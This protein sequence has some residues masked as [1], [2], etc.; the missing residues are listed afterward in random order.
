M[1]LEVVEVLT[2]PGKKLC[3]KHYA[4]QYE[5]IAKAKAQAMA[6]MEAHPWRGMDK[7][8]FRTR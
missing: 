6:N 1:T 7:L 3:E 8:V 2:V 4:L 5:Y